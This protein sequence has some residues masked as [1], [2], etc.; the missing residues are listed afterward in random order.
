MHSL[1]LVFEDGRTA[2]VAAGDSETVY[3][4]ALKNRVRIETDCREGACGTC[5]GR[6]TQGDYRLDDY[7]EEALTA[8]EAAE[9]YVLTCRMRP[10]SDCV[11]ELPYGSERALRD[12][13]ETRPGRVAEVSEVAS[14][15]MRL[16]IEAGDPPI[17]FLPG[18]YVRLR[19][20]G[21]SAQRA[22]SFANPPGEAGPA[23]FYVK[24][25]EGGAMSGYA[26]SRARPGDEIS[27][28]GPFGR[29]YLR[30]PERP[31]LMVAG[32]TGLA[33]MLSMLA[34]LAAEGCDRPIRLLYGAGRPREL[35]ALDRLERFAGM[36]LRLATEIAVVEPDDG[37]T[38]AS[39]RVTGLL[40]PEHVAGGDCDA[41]L[42]GPAAMIEAGRSWLAAQ[43]VDRRRIHSETFLP[44]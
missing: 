38:G 20:P 26:A 8:A 9:R 18:Q 37:W 5:K 14:S 28:T 24:L 42:C 34:A 36:G 43:G 30:P 3:F 32:G 1:T 35:F 29:F 11:I 31:L 40:R 25:L 41:Y 19:V 15:V 4:A 2:R 33:P 21:A 17:P 6:C 39:G 13:P 23:I 12:A 27:L 16:A 7:G 44:A 22:Y 10:L